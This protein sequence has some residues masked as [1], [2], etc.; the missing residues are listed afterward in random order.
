MFPF[1]PM[2][3]D[4]SQEFDTDREV[5]EYR[6]YVEDDGEEDMDGVP[7]WVYDDEGWAYDDGEYDDE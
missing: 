6:T 7:G 3:V 2:A 5:P 4:R 1:K